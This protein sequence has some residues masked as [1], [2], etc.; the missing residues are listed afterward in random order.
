MVHLRVST[1]IAAPPRVCFDL[2]RDVDA[3]LAS[4]AD[5]GERAVTGKTSGLLGLGDEVIWQARHLGVTQRLTSRITAF[6]PPNYFRDRMTRG[7]FR[8]FEHDHHFVP[9]NGGTEMIDVL[10]FAA[11]LGPVG[12]LVERTL[13]AP[14]LRRFLTRRGAALKQ[15]AEAQ[16]DHGQGH[17]A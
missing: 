7:A 16:R 17:P 1:W 3:H 15:M 12:W 11:P 14:H 9:Q 5:T 10:R 8:S 13:L 6:D 2:A 4:A